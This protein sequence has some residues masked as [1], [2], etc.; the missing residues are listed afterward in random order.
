MKQG[1]LPFQYG[2][3][4]SSAGMTALL[5][6]PAYLELL[7]ASGLR[8]SVERHV[9]LR[10]CGQGWTDNQIVTSLMMLNPVSS[11]GQALAGGEPVVDLE[12]LNKDAG[13]CRVLREVET[14]GM[15]LEDILHTTCCPGRGRGYWRWLP[16]RIEHRRPC[17]EHRSVGD[18]AEL[19]GR[20]RA[21]PKLLNTAEGGLMAW[22]RG[23]MG[24]SSWGRN[25]A[26]GPE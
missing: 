3:E 12:V 20:A 24:D 14:Y 8:E 19:P 11:T 10:E 22:L 5:G 6:L 7:H 26:R 2:E 21:F 1:V 9:G 23:W 13:F 16:S 4:R 15:G 25:P 17:L 18:S